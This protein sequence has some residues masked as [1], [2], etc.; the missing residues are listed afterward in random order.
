[1]ASHR[2]VLITGGSGFIGRHVARLLRQRGDEVIVLS[3]HPD[4]ARARLP[5]GVRVVAGLGELADDSRIDAIVNL[6]GAPILGPP[7]TAGRRRSLRDSRLQTTRALVDFCRR[8]QQRPGVL[9]SASAIGYYGIGDDTPADEQTSPQEIFQSRLCR[10][11][12]AAAREA[13]A[14]GLRVVLL[15][16]GIVLGRDGGAL[17]PLAAPVRLGLGAVLGSG[18]QPLPWIHIADAL[19]LLTLAL[20][21]AGLSGPIN[22]VAPEQTVQR[23]FVAALGRVLRR[24]VFFRVPAFILRALLGEMAQLLLDGRPVL[25]A[26]AR[27][28][29][30]AFQHP[31]LEPALA[32]LLARPGGSD[33][34]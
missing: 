32:T 3:R 22:A 11:W 5:A 26:A 20:D 34:D 23:G 27:A 19:G 7:W 21:S 13:E 10:D 1:M 28:A 4:R 18:N 15:R 25:P 2:T 12:E 9:V 6:A 8:L 31:E 29:G 30:Y 17:P 33:L 14:L 16:F 24:P